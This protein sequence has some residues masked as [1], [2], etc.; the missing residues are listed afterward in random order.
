[1][2]PETIPPSADRSAFVGR[3]HHVTA[4]LED[5]LDVLDGGARA[6][7]VRGE[8]GV[9]KTRLVDEYLRRTPLGSRAVGGCVESGTDA[10]AF[11]PVTSVLRPL[12]RDHAPTPV[13][14]RE[15]ARILPELGEV[16]TVPDDGRI[17]LFESVLTFLERCAEA[18]DGT[19]PGLCVVL[20]DLH[21][22]DASTRDLLLFL[23]RNPGRAPLQ[24]LAT[25]RTDDV[26][27]THPLRRLVPD[28]VRLPRV[29]TADLEPLDVAGV[30]A[31]VTA[32]RG[33]APA[34]AEAERL[35]G[36]SGGNP[37]FVEALITGGDGGSGIPEGP[38]ELML[39]RVEA[40][41]SGAR[42]VLGTAALIGTRVPHTLLAAAAARSGVGEE[43]LDA[44]L[45]EAVDARV[46]QVDGDGYTFGHALLAEAV[47]EDLLPGERVRTH[48][49]LADALDAGVPGLAE[50]A[51]DRLLARHATL[52]HDH[53]RAF[54]ATWAVVARDEHTP[55]HPEQLDLLERL[56]ELYEAVP[57]TAAE[58]G[59]TRA[60]LLRRAATAAHLAGRARRARDHATAGLAELGADGDT[61]PASEHRIAAALLR[62]TRARVLRTLGQ[63][64][65][66]EDLDAAAVLFGEDHT[67]RIAV[68]AARAAALNVRGREREAE[69]VARAVLEWARRAGDPHSEADALVTLGSF[70]IGEDADEREHLLRRGI[71]LAARIGHVQTELRGWN[72]LQ[73]AL[74]FRLDLHAT[75]EVARRSMERHTELGVARTRGA[76]AAGNLAAVL[77]NLGHTDAAHR[78][79]DRFPGGDLP[80]RRQKAHIAL[81]IA[82]W[83][84]DVP[85]SRRLLEE[86]TAV[87]EA[88]E[89]PADRRIVRLAARLR[90]LAEEGDLD[91]MG[92]VARAMIDGERSK[93][94]TQ[95]SVDGMAH[96]SQAL[97]H[98]MRSGDPGHRA[99][100][101]EL[102][103]GLELF[104]RGEV[105]AQTP[106]GR[107]REQQSR[108]WLATDPAE[109]LRL[110]EGYATALGEVGF[111]V[112][113]TVALGRAASFAA[114]CG[115]EG[116]A[117]RLLVLCDEV[118]G[119]CDNGAA[120]LRRHAAPVRA[121][122]GEPGEAPAGLTRREQEVLV[123][124]AAGATNREIGEALFISPKTVSVHMSNLMSKLGVTNRN[125]AAVRARDLGLT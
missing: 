30:A 74:H 116:D 112:Q 85:T 15:L 93:A 66:L 123:R 101:E 13:E 52:A 98:L 106:R 113:R 87:E 46:L 33:H 8:A 81:S 84:G 72:N 111:P 34:D 103:P 90:L 119:Q 91:A 65:D 1:M 76:E 54:R 67:G 115:R 35:H 78:L 92:P 63:D 97:H 10:V 88:V 45:R 27:R 120:L 94:P 73:V 55:G 68:D 9:G 122:L 41:S 71:A 121:V 38:R 18:G 49:N 60:D 107:L 56:L 21:W 69:P 42:S 57:A 19:R 114:E 89:L 99:L 20:E 82:L 75:L 26:H 125:A 83:E 124:L 43:D 47:Q 29:G 23:L 24:I 104:R 17:R 5:A 59:A 77:V 12:A 51:R 37:L 7:F 28:M 62:L 53:E 118:A 44:A 3:D 70:W 102:R 36:R 86:L 96:F 64:G 40:L 16:S 22:A 2:P 32:L 110:W 117:R 58:I 105:W 25:V 109:A 108:A 100:A 11:A 80:V 48:R 39:R 61:P 50:P 79:F 4:L 14:A 31:Q 95:A 6:V